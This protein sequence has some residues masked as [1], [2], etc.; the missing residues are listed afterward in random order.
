[1]SI[2][3]ER[4]GTDG[5]YRTTCLIGEGQ[6]IDGLEHPDVAV[7]LAVRPLY[8]KGVAV[9]TD[10]TEDQYS[11]Y[12]NGHFLGHVGAVKKESGL[13]KP[14]EKQTPAQKAAAKLKAR[15]VKAGNDRN[16]ALADALAESLSDEEVAEILAK[17][18]IP[19]ANG[20]TEV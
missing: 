19:T 6:S 17:A 14:T 10:E 9:K 7:E 11:E 15:T 12:L 16:K 13:L 18:G 20:T 3:T 4:V 5:I 1:M 2:H 8:R